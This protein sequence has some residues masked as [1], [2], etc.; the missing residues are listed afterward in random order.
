MIVSD[1]SD[2]N[3]HH[4][5]SPNA[6]RPNLLSG[7][8]EGLQVWGYPLPESHSLGYGYPEQSGVT[9]LGITIGPTRGG[10]SEQEEGYDQG[11][12]SSEE[13][14][15]MEGVEEEVEGSEE[16]GSN[17]FVVPQN[18]GGYQYH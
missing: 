6:I 8:N 1:H 10:V 2:D 3:Q 5:E 17:N 18:Y 11:V 15:T 16:H 13:Y 12:V 9:G 14:A 4:H 7:H